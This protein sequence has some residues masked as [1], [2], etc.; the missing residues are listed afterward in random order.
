MKH[1]YV[2]LVL[3]FLACQ[4][5]PPLTDLEQLKK[6][7]QANK[8]EQV[9]N[10]YAVKD[11][12]FQDNPVALNVISKT[13]IGLYHYQR[14]IEYFDKAIE[15]TPFEPMIYLPKHNIKI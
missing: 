15:L 8:F 9:L 11:K 3:L 10:F 7:Y 14:A 5:S 6:F 4:P 12:E 13:Y 2:C 1:I